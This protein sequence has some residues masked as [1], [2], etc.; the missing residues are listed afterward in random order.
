MQNFV[1]FSPIFCIFLKVYNSTDLQYTQKLRG[2]VKIAIKV[3]V[4]ETI[5][6][7]HPFLLLFDFLEE[8][9]LTFTV[10]L[11]PRA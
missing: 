11:F 1:S 9:M 5:L 2:F 8:I 3:Y 7:L 10:D 4:F 6:F